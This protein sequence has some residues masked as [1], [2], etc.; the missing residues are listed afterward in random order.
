MQ[1]C[2]LG[3]SPLRHVLQNNLRSVPLLPAPGAGAGRR[4]GLPAGK[5]E[6]LPPLSEGLGARRLTS[7][8]LSFPVLKMDQA[9]WF[10]DL[11]LFPITYIELVLT[12]CLTKL[13]SMEFS[14]QEC[15]LEMNLTWIRSSKFSSSVIVRG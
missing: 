1:L 4:G 6:P 14:V 13:G 5:Q 15:L 10:S 9:M 12:G 3:L 11:C 8:S 2:T 7:Q